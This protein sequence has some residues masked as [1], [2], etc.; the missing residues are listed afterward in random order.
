MKRDQPRGFT[1]I[2]LLVV[3]SIISLLI[4]LL[5]PALQAARD[6]A[7][8]VQCLSNQR[9]VGQIAHV[10]ANDYDEWTFPQ[11]NWWQSWRVTWDAAH[12]LSPLYEYLGENLDQVAFEG[13]PVND[14]EGLSYRRNYWGNRY[15]IG[16]QPGPYELYT[17][18]DLGPHQLSAIIHPSQKILIAETMTAPVDARNG[19]IQTHYEDLGDHHTGGGNLLFV[20]GN[21]RTVAK[22][23]L[24][25]PTNP[26][27][28]R[29][30]WLMAHRIPGEY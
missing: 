10:Y 29:M 9:Q 4:A 27:Q 3:I 18:E 15:I 21:A 30:D 13:C 16:M 24:A 25:N 19:F 5:M 23:E 11:R 17:G 14:N 26:S 2:E 6:V 20:D 12:N 7:R 22:T 8:Q 1:L 28:V